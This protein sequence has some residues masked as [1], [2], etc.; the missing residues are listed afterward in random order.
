MT[1]R[2]RKPLVDLMNDENIRESFTWLY[3]FLTQ[4]PLLN[5][6]FEHFEYTIEQAVTDE[7][8]PHKL[9]FTPKDIILTYVVPNTVTVTF[10]YENFDSQNLVVTTSGACTFRVFAGRY[11]NEF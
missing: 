2:L 8:L 9:G 10:D 6:D 3:E 5:G 1:E 7:K 4:I 11:V